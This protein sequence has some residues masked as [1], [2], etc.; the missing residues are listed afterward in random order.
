MVADKQLIADRY[1]SDTSLITTPGPMTVSAVRRAL[2]PSLPHSEFLLCAQS[3]PTLCDSMDCSLPSASVHGI[4]RATILE[5]VA[6]SYSRGSSW[7]RDWTHISCVS[8]IGRRIL[9]LWATWEA[10]S[11]SIS[12][13]QFS[14]PVMSDSLRPQESQHARP[15][16][17]SPTP[18]VYPNPCPLSQWCH[19]AI[20]SSVVPFSSCPQPL[21]HP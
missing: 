7:P 14:R 11:L 10:P 13:V 12:S 9:Y 4:F 20:S 1:R 17:P 16:C 6:I 2:V 15:P 8:C 18:R 21:Q 3:C 19:P 5:W